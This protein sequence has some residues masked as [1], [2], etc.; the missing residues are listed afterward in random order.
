MTEQ[1]KTIESRQ[2]E[3]AQLL[4]MADVH[5][6]IHESGVALAALG[7]SELTA[8][9]AKID[10]NPFSIRRDVRD[11]VIGYWARK[12]A[13][14]GIPDD[15]KTQQ[16]YAVL[17][18]DQLNRFHDLRRRII[19]AELA[20]KEY[21]T[22]NEMGSTISAE[23]D[24]ALAALFADIDWDSIDLDAE[25][26]AATQDG[27][28]VA[29]ESDADPVHKTEPAE[30][31]MT[32]AEIQG[33]IS[34][35]IENKTSLIDDLLTSPPDYEQADVSTLSRYLYGLLNRGT[36]DHFAAEY[37]RVLIER[38]GD[39]RLVRN[40]LRVLLASDR[41]IDITSLKDFY[42]YV[43]THKD[44][45]ETLSDETKR[46]Q[47]EVMAGLLKQAGML[48]EQYR[49][50]LQADVTALLETSYET[51]MKLIEKKQSKAELPKA[52]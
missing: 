21:G 30:A 35:A 48:H 41:L 50:S 33:M 37:D 42:E 39:F 17:L 6:S 7:S 43:E 34:S 45:P 9:A 31:P 12:N 3:A 36:I 8:A 11:I 1:L 29:P 46:T 23:N 19:D 4:E 20:V 52:A 47:L 25:V 10:E 28:A 14:R 2:T 38:P 15:E 51:G 22:A 18:A 40:E 5:M 13:L 26:T 44:D 49:N 32:E 24:E 27:D 16:S